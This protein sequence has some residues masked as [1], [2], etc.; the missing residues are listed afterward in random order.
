MMI[1]K[2]EIKSY[3]EIRIGTYHINELPSMFKNI[4]TK[5][6]PVALAASNPILVS[7]SH[8]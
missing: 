5:L 4:I 2:K 8:A 1:T 7:K 6:A 3:D